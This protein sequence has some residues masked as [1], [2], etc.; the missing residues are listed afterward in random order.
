M[1]SPGV[2][3]LLL[4]LGALALVPACERG[5]P[6]PQRDAEKGQPEVGATGVVATVNGVPIFERDVK[7]KLDGSR[8]GNPAAT[9]QEQ[10]VLEAL[11]RQELTRQRAEQLGLDADAKYQEQ[12][13]E[14]E[15]QVNA[16]KRQ[17]LSD[18]FMR[19][20]MSKAPPPTEAE[21][22]AYFAQNAERLRTELH[23]W[24]ILARD[25]ATA[26][27]ALSEVKAGTPFEAV[28]AK[29]FPTL[30]LGQA[31]W[32]LGYLKWKQV[33]EPWQ[34]VVYDLADGQVS[35][36]IAGP[37]NRFWVLKRVGRRTDPSVTLESATPAVAEVLAAQKLAARRS[38]IDR[39][40]REGAKVVIVRPD[41]PTNAEP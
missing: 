28:A 30:P 32:D 37:G 21:V 5:G 10:N 23:V 2:V 36:V 9:G 12:L 19:D 14:R 17:A 31:P 20:L 39:E 26:E 6:A 41:V 24:Q 34:G 27:R 33:P 22:A 35:E 29:Q 38:D 1:S 11:I 3:S 25:R 4:A 7:L 40:L 16:F 13:R 15:A 18:L 8:H